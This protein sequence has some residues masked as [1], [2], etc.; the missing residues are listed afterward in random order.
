MYDAEVATLVTAWYS[1]DIAVLCK[2]R[3]ERDVLPGVYHVRDTTGQEWIV[4]IVERAQQPSLE[5]ASHLLQWLEHVQYPA[6]RLRLP[7]PRRQ[8]D[9]VP[10]YALQMLTFIPGQPL[11]RSPEAL[12]MLASMLARLHILASN[13]LP[14]VNSWWYSP[15]VFGETVEQLHRGRQLVPDRYQMLIDQLLAVVGRLTPLQA[16]GLIHG[17]CWYANAIRVHTDAVVLIDWDGAGRG[18]PILDLGALLL[19]SHYDLTNPLDVIVTPERINAIMTGYQAIRPLPLYEQEYLAASIPFYLAFNAGR[20]LASLATID[21]AA[22]FQFQKL[23][24]RLEATSA[25]SNVA[26][27]FLS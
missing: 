4:R 26:L 17:D 2:L 16:T 15:T 3:G 19:T 5:H 11:N 1:C 8:P 23:T 18:S 21:D 13:D 27:Q 14:P 6:P 25:I 7:T 10:Q 9:T 22:V 12:G 24:A 20:L